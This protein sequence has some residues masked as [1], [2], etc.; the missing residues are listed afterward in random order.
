MEPAALGA[1]T[2]TQTR[3]R[4]IH[5]VANAATLTPALDHCVP[6]LNS[7]NYSK[8]HQVPRL[9]HQGLCVAEHT[10]PGGNGSRGAG[11]RIRENV[12]VY[13]PPASGGQHINE[14]SYPAK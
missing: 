1:M 10:L 6:L 11:S 12:G 8:R 9:Y 3:E 4:A 5:F 13:C 7:A 14:V 2:V